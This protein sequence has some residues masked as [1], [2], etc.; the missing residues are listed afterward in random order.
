MA[1][2]LRD[3][4]RLLGQMR[5]ER[6]VEIV[7]VG[8]RVGEHEGGLHLAVDVDQ[9]VEHFRRAAQRI[10]A[11]VEEFDLRAEDRGGTLGLVAA[12]AFT[13]PA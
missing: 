3:D 4:A 11:R 12:P 10:V 13:P 7:R 6:M 5:R 8:Q 1:G 9:P 2:G